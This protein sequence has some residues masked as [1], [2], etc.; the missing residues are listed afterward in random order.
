MKPTS[1]A[2]PKEKIEELGKRI[3]RLHRSLLDPDVLQGLLPIK[4]GLLPRRMRAAEA[5]AREDRFRAAAEPYVRTLADDSA[6]AANMR[7]MQLDGL[8]W[9]VP[10]LRP[11]EEADVQRYMRHQNFPY[12][13]ITQTREVA[14]GGIM[15]DLGCNNGRMAIPRAILGDVTAVYGAE[16]DP[17]NY[18]CLVRNVR[19]NH[20]SGIVMPDWAA[21]GSEN[22]VVRL[23]RAK[24][25][26]GHKVIGAAAT[27]R[28]ETVDVPSFTLDSWID[29]LGIASE[30]IA[31]VKVDVQGSEMAVLRG[32]AR[33]LQ[34]RH[35]AWQ[36]EIDPPLL[37]ERQ[38]T[39]DDLYA[40]LREHFTHFIDLN[41]QLT[42][43]RVQPTSEMTTALSYILETSDGRTD[44][45][46]F[47]VQ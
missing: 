7:A 35:I 6:F 8:R 33:V 15:L 32:A 4:A 20:L 44:V 37:A 14:L 26:G 3:D 41:R 1:I 13:A 46:L 16:P 27:A 25:A 19:D 34:Q 10:L 43:P 47:S 11:D 21:I 29:R 42:G 9:W 24:H 39:T 12:R 31:F 45:L 28:G 5:R 23:G 38:L 17:L 30:D 40:T 22:G 18:A 2:N 36:M